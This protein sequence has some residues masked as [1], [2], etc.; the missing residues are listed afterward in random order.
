MAER[1]LIVMVV[2]GLIVLAGL[3]N[4]H[5]RTW[6]KRRSAL[7]LVKTTYGAH[8]VGPARL[9]RLQEAG[10]VDRFESL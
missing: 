2:A 7:F 5:L 3:V 1:F 6:H 9:K 8:I 10:L 4:S